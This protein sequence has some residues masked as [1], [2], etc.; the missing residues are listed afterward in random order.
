[1]WRIKL[2]I[3]LLLMYAATLAGYLAGKTA[4]DRYYA[5]TPEFAGLNHVAFQN[6]VTFKGPTYIS[7]SIFEGKGIV[8]A[9]GTQLI[10]AQNSFAD[11]E[12][13]CSLEIQ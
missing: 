4:A 13:P 6:A 8:L 5:N 10:L 9:K 3:A 2:S 1:M 11:Q 12:K 7:N